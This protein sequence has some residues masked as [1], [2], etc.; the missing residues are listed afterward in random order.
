M[1]GIGKV[2]V[3]SGKVLFRGQLLHLVIEDQK[4]TAIQYYRN[5]IIPT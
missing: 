4:N 1:R 5:P 3:Q 2:Q